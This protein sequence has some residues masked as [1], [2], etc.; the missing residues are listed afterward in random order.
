MEVYIEDAEFGW[1]DPK[2]V[3]K[4]ND[5]L[6]RVITV[7]EEMELFVVKRNQLHFRQSEHVSTPFTTETTKQ[8]YDWNKSTE[9]AEETL[10]GIY[11][12]K[13]DAKLTEIMKVVLTNCVQT[14]PP[15]KTNP[16]KTVA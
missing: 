8:K 6:W 1:I 16:E 13:E 11:D 12:N 9:E 10:K 2:K 15:K 7:P 14:A 4:D 5:P 3:D